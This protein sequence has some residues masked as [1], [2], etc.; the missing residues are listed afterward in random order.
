MKNLQ[1]E[2]EERKDSILELSKFIYEH[3][4]IEMQEFAAKKKLVEM[5]KAEGFDVDEDIPGLPTA[6]VAKKSSGAGPRVGFIAEY[7]ALPQMGHA[8]GHNLI[9][10]MGYG[11]AVTL[12]AMLEDYKGSVY[13][14]GAPA[15]ETGRGK[16]GL[17]DGGY[18]KN[19]DVAVMAHPMKFYGLSSP[20]INLEGYDIT[21]HGRASH[22]G[23]SPSHGINALDAAVVFYTAIGVMRQQVRDGARIHGIITN[24]GAA[25]NIIPDTASLRIEI[26]DSDIVYFKELVQRVLSAAKAAAV[27]CG[28]T[29]DIEMFEPSICCMKNNR[30]MLELFKKH[31]IESGV[32]PSEIADTFVSGG[33]S[34]MGNVSQVVPSIHP[35]LGMVGPDSEAHTLEFLRDAGGEKAASEVLRAVKCMA[36]LGLDILSNPELLAEIKEDFICQ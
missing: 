12:A 15:E 27:A 31:L 5:L 19:V 36:G 25:V 17:I 6:F 33:C 30:V 7:D 18:F 4:E 16:P 24:G 2:L 21:F 23:G 35:W 9:A 8:C 34:D 20:L 10:A 3:P 29:V 11:S 32:K 14:F 22:A 13:L 1:C 28:C 26:R